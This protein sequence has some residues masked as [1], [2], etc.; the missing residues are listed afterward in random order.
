[1]LVQPSAKAST[2]NPSGWLLMFALYVSQRAGVAEEELRHRHRQEEAGGWDCCEYLLP[3]MLFFFFLSIVWCKISLMI[4]QALLIMNLWPNL[5][6]PTLFS[7][8]LPI[9]FLLFLAPSA[10]LQVLLMQES[11]RRII[12]AEESKMGKGTHT[13]THRTAVQQSNK[14]KLF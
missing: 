1:M 12:E 2:V 11:V 5:I 3:E 9:L 7:L 10:P 14:Q 8:A 6:Y 4:S 13:Y